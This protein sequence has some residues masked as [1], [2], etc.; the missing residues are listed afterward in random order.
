M[1]EIDLQI[2]DFMI[3][4]STKGLSKKTINSYESTLRLLANYLERESGVESANNAKRLNLKAYIDI[5][6][7]G[8]RI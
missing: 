7:K 3:E 8:E 5:Y 1:H 4:C 6:K 2:D